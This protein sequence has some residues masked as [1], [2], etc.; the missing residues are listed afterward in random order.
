MRQNL[1][2]FVDAVEKILVEQKQLE[3]QSD[4]TSQK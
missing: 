3:L 4:D 2:S 1:S